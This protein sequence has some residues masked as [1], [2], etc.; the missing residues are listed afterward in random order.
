[1]QNADDWAVVGLWHI[2][3]VISGGD[4]NLPRILHSWQYVLS[5]SIFYSP[6]PPEDSLHSSNNDHWCIGQYFRRFELILQQD[7][8]FAG[9]VCWGRFRTVILNF[10]IEEPIKSRCNQYL[11]IRLCA[12]MI[13]LSLKLTSQRHKSV[14]FV[15]LTQFR[16]MSFKTILS[17]LFH[18]TL[19]I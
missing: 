2:T 7:K 15:T 9:Q 8:K 6:N 3:G 12:P 4:S 17:A 16:K 18:H 10:D 19:S 5:N 13:V 14:C 11:T 1:M